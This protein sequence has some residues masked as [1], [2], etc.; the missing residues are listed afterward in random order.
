MTDHTA[1]ANEP[2]QLAR[3]FFV[4]TGLGVCT[5]VTVVILVVLFMPS[6]DGP[7]PVVPTPDT[8]HLAARP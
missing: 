1:A 2:E 8:Q 4:L 7:V 3:K 5:F 6:N